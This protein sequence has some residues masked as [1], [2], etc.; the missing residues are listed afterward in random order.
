MAN[1]LRTSDGQM[2]IKWIRR[3]SLDGQKLHFTLYGASGG[4][5]GKA[6]MTADYIRDYVLIN[7]IPEA[8]EARMS[9]LCEELEDLLY[10]A[11]EEHE[12]SYEEADLYSEMANLYNAL[13]NYMG[14]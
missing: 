3:D 2:S 1:L 11:P 4:V 14:D 12:C 10:N 13:K 7:S 6:P 8:K 9:K 5:I